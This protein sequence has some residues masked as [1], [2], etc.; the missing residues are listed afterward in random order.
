MEV[1]GG[2]PSRRRKIPMLV[3]AGKEE[4]D[5]FDFAVSVRHI[6]KNKKG[7][8]MKFGEDRK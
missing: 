7:L 3:P 1:T 8:E 5:V 6:P 4:Y 2:E